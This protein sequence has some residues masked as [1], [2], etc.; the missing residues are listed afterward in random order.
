MPSDL[1]I[2]LANRPG[3]AAQAA[4]ALGGAGINIDGG[5]GLAVGDQGVLHVLVEDADG[6]RQA[7]TQAGLDVG[8]AREVV[9]VDVANEPGALGRILRRVADAGVNVEAMYS[10]ADARVVLCADDIGRARE[11]AAG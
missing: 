2:R 11:A 6:A 4:E 10:T 7:L 3:T 9:I 1:S 8:E 5:A